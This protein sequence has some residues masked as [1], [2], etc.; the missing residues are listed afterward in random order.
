MQKEDLFA[1]IVDNISSEYGIC[2]ILCFQK[3]A[4]FQ[5][6]ILEQLNL[7]FVYRLLHVNY[8]Y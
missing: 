8:Y 5:E 2:F 4:R 3:E 6:W 1:F 7:T